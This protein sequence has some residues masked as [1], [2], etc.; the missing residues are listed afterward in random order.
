[1][2]RH[3]SFIQSVRAKRMDST[4]SAEAES[5]RRMSMLTRAR[6]VG[7]QSPRARTRPA[8]DGCTWRLAGAGGGRFFGPRTRQP[9]ALPL[10]MCVA[11]GSVLI[12]ALG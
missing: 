2:D 7:R 10:Y 12:L 1:M 8:G 6:K 3:N 9:R 4:A 5:A 11:T